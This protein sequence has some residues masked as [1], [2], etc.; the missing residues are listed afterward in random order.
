VRY[1]SYQS[2]GGNILRLVSSKRR[3][4]SDDQEVRAL[5]WLTQ[6]VSGGMNHVDVVVQRWQTLSGKEAVP[7]RRRQHV[8]VNGTGQRPSTPSKCDSRDV[9]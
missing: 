4:Y 8:L 5:L 1:D 3:L 7:G 2:A 9:Q 6:H